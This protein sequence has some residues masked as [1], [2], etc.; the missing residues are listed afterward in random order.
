M[1]VLF[2]FPVP[3]ATTNPYATQLLRSVEPLAECRTFSWRTALTGRY[4]VFHAHWPEALLRGR[5]G[6]R[7]ALRQALFALLLAR[8][9]VQRRTAV[10]RTVH[11]VAPHEAL[12]P[13]QRRLLEAFD[14]RTD[15]WI[16]LNRQT[17]TPDPQR[18]STILHGHYTDWY[19]DYQVPAAVPGR[20]LSFG[21]LRPYKGIEDLLGAL[22][23]IEDPD[24]TCVIQGQPISAGYGQELA[25]LAAADPRVDLRLGF[26]PEA[27]LAAEVGRAS[28]VILPY[29]GMLNSG[30]A[31][32]SLSL[33]RPILMPRTNANQDLADEVGSDWVEMFD[34]PLTA[35][36]VAS[37]LRRATTLSADAGRPGIC[38]DL[39]QREWP[40]IGA[41]HVDAYARARETASAAG[42]AAPAAQLA[43]ASSQQGV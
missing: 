42:R 9:A 7:Q 15:H 23:Q 12:D 19:R 14:R 37:S 28:L 39:S 8:L 24:V 31:L 22:R 38:P 11:N 4:D 17:D 32:L 21:F 26:A 20:L 3:R 5:T 13:V 34:H 16:R 33:G 41:A 27:E 43:P 29:R 18:T 35:E 6:S 36:Q 10:V 30:V 40:A 2:S 25:R 1:R